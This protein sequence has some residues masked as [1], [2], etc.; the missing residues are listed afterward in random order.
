MCLSNLKPGQTAIVVKIAATGSVR[1]RIM[2]MGLCRGSRV[3]VICCAPLGDPMELELRD[4]KLSL[5]KKEAQ[6]IFVE[7]DS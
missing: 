2:D 5:R 7:A 3:K 6:T 1:R 4:Y